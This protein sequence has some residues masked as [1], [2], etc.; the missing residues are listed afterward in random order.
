MRCLVI[1]FGCVAHRARAPPCVPGWTRVAAQALALISACAEEVQAQWDVYQTEL[2]N[3]FYGGEPKAK[4]P[5][6]VVRPPPASIV[7]PGLAGT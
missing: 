6:K 3:K 1:S 4:K 5:L 2:V 7:V